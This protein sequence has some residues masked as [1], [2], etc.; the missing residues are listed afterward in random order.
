MH[1]FDFNDLEAFTERTEKQM[2]TMNVGQMY[3]Q[4]LQAQKESELAKTYLEKEKKENQEM[5]SER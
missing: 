4:N 2:N 3:I 1:V 5:I